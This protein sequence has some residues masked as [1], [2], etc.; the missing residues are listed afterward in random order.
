MTA[1]LKEVVA[2]FDYT[3]SVEGAI[4]ALEGCQSKEDWKEKILNE[5]LL[6]GIKANQIGN[7]AKS[8]FDS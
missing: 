8:V 6:R 4:K 2:E 1:F 3:G 5:T 7:I